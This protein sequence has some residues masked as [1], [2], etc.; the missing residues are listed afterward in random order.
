MD[1]YDFDDNNIETRNRITRSVYTSTSNIPLEVLYESI[2]EQ[3]Q[4]LYV[5]K[6][7]TA[8]EELIKL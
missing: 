7:K 2:P 8:S 1:D 3:P 6:L 5:P 4:T